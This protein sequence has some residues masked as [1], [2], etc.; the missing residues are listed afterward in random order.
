MSFPSPQ[1][2]Q[3]ILALAIPILGGMLSQNV[4]NM[5]DTA[6]VGVLG[7]EALA[8]VGLGSFASFM[9][10]AFLMGMSVG[11]QAMA[12]RRLGEGR[13]A[14]TAL[15]LNGGLALVVLIAVPAS[16][17]LFVLIPD[18]YPFLNRDPEVIE[19]GVPYLQVRVLAMAGVGMNF[20]FR[21]YWNAVNLSRLY[22]RT[23]VVMHVANI[24]LNWVLIFGHLGFPQLGVLGAGI[25]TALA[26][27]L[28]TAHYFVLALRR[29]RSTGFL[30][31]LPDRRTTLTLLRLSVPAGVQQ[32]L[33]A[34][35]LTTLFWIMGQL[36]TRELAAANVIT[37]LTLV[38]ILP[39][40][41]FGLAAASLVGQA[42]GR[43]DAPDAARWGWEVSRLA[44]VL[45][46]VLELPVA[47]YPELFLRIFLHDPETLALASLPLRL[48]AM[49]LWFDAL[50]TV[51]L[52]AHQGAGH[53][54]R[55][56]AISV[57]MQWAL[58]LPL[59]YVIGPLLGFGLL[60]IW[61]ANIAYRSIQTLIFA[62]S[63]RQGHW[64]AVR[65]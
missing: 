11:V 1:R 23:L 16:A 8:A 40:I 35:G 2:R 63:W 4:L 39:M 48:V 60:E 30:H 42:L 57:T 6:M 33:F 41:G 50:G 54:R 43:R 27:Y 34:T 59:A 21:G 61:C 29:A 36:G 28:G 24:F 7:D 53:N 62:W 20:A 65:V 45:V 25:A 13:H 17:L 46:A 32:F 38:G 10:M 12:A 58:F 44:M 19:L 15:P 49:T 51:L 64:A 5:V 37:N 55:A 3:R 9:A 14:E 26:T 18:L 52:S 56:M 47:I 22:M 31:G